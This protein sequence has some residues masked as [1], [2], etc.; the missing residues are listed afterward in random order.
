MLSTAGAGL[1][2]S[3]GWLLQ[4]LSRLP[5]GFAKQQ[6]LI[7]ALKSA[8]DASLASPCGSH[9]VNRRYLQEALYSQHT[10]C[11]TTV[12]YTS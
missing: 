8:K 9:R 7:E 4:L 1:V 3:N 11:Y 6:M 5:D 2:N 10:V 12:C